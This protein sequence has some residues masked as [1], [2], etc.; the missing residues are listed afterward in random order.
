MINWN[1]WQG[2]A[3][4]WD[5]QLMQFPDYTIY[6]SYGWGEHRSHFGWRPYRLT[7]VE[8]EQT[9]AMA[10]VLVRRFPFSTALV[11]AP[12]GPVGNISAWGKSFQSSLQLAIGTKRVYC[13]M[14]PMRKQVDQEVELIRSMGWTKAKSPL[15]SGMSAVY[16]PSEPQKVREEKASYN[17]RRN[18]RRSQK[19]EHMVDVWQ[20]PNIDEIMAVYEAMQ[21]YKKIDQQISKDALKSILERFG[22]NCVVVRCS[23]SAGRLLALRGALLLGDRG[24]DIFAAATPE[25]RK[26]YASHAA[27]WELMEQ[28][29]SRGVQW[30]DMSGIDPVG[31]KGVYDFKM[32]TGA[33]EVLHLGEWDWATSSL[34][35]HVANYLIKKRGVG[36]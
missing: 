36:G 24:W 26:V 20:K 28:C 18:L 17:W 7:A 22:E 30:Y 31:N 1:L 14:N 33:C 25:A 34:L 15:L 5:R 19:Y 4:T 27:L 2:D 29:A 3:T 9:I 11:W 35:R 16:F 12:G 32:G 13:R 6:Q 21:T 10:Q 23:D 8:N